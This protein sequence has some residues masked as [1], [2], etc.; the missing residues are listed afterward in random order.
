MSST[1]T[2]LDQAESAFKSNQ[3]PS[4]RA[5][6]EHFGVSYT[7]LQNRIKGSKAREQTISPCRRLTNT[8]ES[9]L[10]ARLL[11]LDRRGQPVRTGFVKEYANALLACKVDSYSNQSSP[12][13]GANWVSNFVKRHS[14]LRSRYNRKYDYQRAKC[15][16]RALMKE[17]LERMG[18]VIARYGIVPEDIYNFDETGFQMGAISTAKVITASQMAGRPL[19][20][21]PGSREWVTV[22]EAINCTGWALDPMIIFKAKNH[23]N[24]WY[25]D[26]ELGLDWTIAVSDNGWTNND[27]GLHWLEHVFDRQTKLRTTGRKRLLILDGHGSHL[28]PRFYDYCMQND[29]E[30]LCMPPH[31]SHLLQPLDV[32][33]FSALK[34]GYGKRVEEFGK[35]S[36][37]R[38]TKSDF[39][40]FY[41]PTRKD[42]FT[43]NNIRN[44][45]AACGIVPLDPARVIGRLRIQVRTPSPP[46]N[47]TEGPSQSTVIK[48]PDRPDEIRA[49]FHAIRMFHSS[50]SVDCPASVSLQLDKLERAC[51]RDSIISTL[52]K[53][54]NSDFRC[55]KVRQN[56]RKASKR[57]YIQSGGALSVQEGIR[58]SQSS[59]EITDTPTAP[60][61]SNSTSGMKPK[62][63]YHCSICASQQHTARTCP[64]KENRNIFVIAS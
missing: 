49:G 46:P 26:R 11:D 10:V 15:E 27:L 1:S 60:N 38:V 9:L 57:A 18:N 44:S 35:G 16:D 4:I 25:L 32:G 30:C 48:T 39:L 33:C 31:S 51:E 37:I 28:Q 45:F 34:R 62:A 63:V 56:T 6:A 2:S 47:Q 41:I 59:I 52:L 20:T 22:I 3:I 40:S 36:E 19:T 29:I 54:E 21:Q 5:A 50:L 17:W 55:V 43:K 12:K 53:R 42:T 58:L 7:T 61:N 64:E 13:V 23:Q 8:E 24:N 14:E